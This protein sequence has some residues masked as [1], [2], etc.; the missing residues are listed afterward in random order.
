M[1]VRQRFGQGIV[2]APVGAGDCFGARPL[3]GVEGRQ[4][5]RLLPQVLDQVLA[6]TMPLSVC[7][8]ISVSNWTACR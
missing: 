4:N 3:D 8:A 6:S 1:R 5:D 7:K 2:D